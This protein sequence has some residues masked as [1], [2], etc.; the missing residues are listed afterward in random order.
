MPSLDMPRSKLATSIARPCNRRNSAA[1][2]VLSIGASLS[3]SMAVA[4]EPPQCA[5]THAF[6]QAD[7]DAAKGTTPV[8]SDEEGNLMFI[9]PLN[10]NT[11][12]TR[13]SYSVSDFWGQTN[14]L[15]NLCN[16]MSDGCE[17][18]GKEALKRRRLMTQAAAAAQWPK[19]Q[20]AATNLSSQIIP[21]PGGKPCAEVDGFLVS[22]T[23]LHKPVVSNACDISN[24]IDALKVPALVIPK[25]PKGGQSLFSKRGAKVGD[26]VIAMPSDTSRTVPGVV[27]DTGPVNL[28]GEASI[29]M[30]AKLLGKTVEPKNY[31]D[32]LKGWQAPRSFV[33]IF[34]KSRNTADPCMTQARIE[35]EAVKRFDAWGGQA[36]ARACVKAYTQT[37]R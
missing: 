15:N 11:D 12:G 31:P 25:D 8:W 33:L 22:S 16:A 19:D 35:P 10:V 24:Y 34:A 13:R 23:A 30:N 20:L 1:V 5:M 32:V 37:L 36:R 6:D 14:A 17:G 21:M 2:F 28:L 27:G 26:L 7:K 9:A 29:A 18:L 4:A 3:T